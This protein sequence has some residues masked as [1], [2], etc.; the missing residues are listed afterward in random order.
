[1]FSYLYTRHNIDGV[2]S[3]FAYDVRG[4]FAFVW[5]RIHKISYSNTIVVL[6]AS[7]IQEYQ[8]YYILLVFVWSRIN[9][10][11]KILALRV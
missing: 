7:E 2:L 10:T 3:T 1:M 8:F 11:A 5:V 4:K 9:M 6:C